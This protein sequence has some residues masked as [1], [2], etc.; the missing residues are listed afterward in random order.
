M[1]DVIKDISD[2][3]FLSDPPAPSDVIFI[4]GGSY[5]ELPEH[6]AR[7]WREGFA[8][9]AVPTGRYSVKRGSFA[10]VRTKAALYN[11]NYRTECEF[12]TE[13]LIRNGVPASAIL[14]EDRSEYTQQN[15]FFSRAL[16]DGA[17]LRIETA[18][19][20]CKGFHARR[21][22]TYWQLAYPDTRFLVC[23]VC[24]DGVTKENWFLSEKGVDRVLG[25][26]ARCGNQMT[27]D[28]KRSLRL[29]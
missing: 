9:L 24:P 3:I 5:P 7:L 10:G 15:A 1:H 18:I 2:F 20:V 29:L 23:P 4:A 16:T 14:P 17:G 19:I 27:A 13:V 28:V 22:C 25:E 6:A 12:M 8:P 26:L 11:G 21:C